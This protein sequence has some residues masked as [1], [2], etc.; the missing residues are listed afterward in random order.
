MREFLDGGLRQMSPLLADAAYSG[1]EKLLPL[2]LGQADLRDGPIAGLAMVGDRIVDVRTHAVAVQMLA[3]AVANDAS[4]L[5][6]A[7]SSGCEEAT[8]AAVKVARTLTAVATLV[9]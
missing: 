6:A 1:G 9:P 2:G 7:S 8:V 5:D 4:A 3:K